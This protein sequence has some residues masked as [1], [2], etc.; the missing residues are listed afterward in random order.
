MKIRID[1]CVIAFPVLFQAK[2]F[3]DSD[4]AFSASFILTPESSIVT[5]A[6]GKRGDITHLKEA[7]V[8]LAQQEWP[9]DYQTVLKQLAAQDKLPYHDGDLKANYEGFPGHIYINSRSKSRPRVLDRDGSPLT[10]ADGKIY[11]GCRV[12]ARVNA[13][14]QNN[15]YGKRVNATLKGVQFHADDKPLSGDAP[16]SDDEFELDESG[17]ADSAPAADAFQL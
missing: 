1:N 3:K 17:S 12:N 2:A 11:S 7:I 10:E 15:N 4:P 9:K 13:W 6:D 16:A 5:M 14:V 8:A